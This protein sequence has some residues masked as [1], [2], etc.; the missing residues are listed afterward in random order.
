MDAVYVVLMS[1]KAADVFPVLQTEHI[2]SLVPTAGVECR[3]S[4][5]LVRGH[6][7][8]VHIRLLVRTPVTR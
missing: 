7:H 5:R 8:C 2:H 3:A 1:V 6:Q 4:R